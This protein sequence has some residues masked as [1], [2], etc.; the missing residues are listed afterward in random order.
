MNRADRCRC[1]RGVQALLGLIVVAGLTTQVEAQGETPAATLFLEAVRLNQEGRFDLADARFREVAARFPRSEWA[2]KASARLEPNGVLACTTLRSSGPSENRI[3]IA[4]M[5]DGF[6]R[7]QGEQQLFNELAE[8]AVRRLFS[9]SPFCEYLSFFNVHRI[10]LASAGDTV[11]ENGEVADTALKARRLPGPHGYVAVDPDRVRE[12][13]QGFQ[14]ND[15]LAVVLVHRAEQGSAA[16]GVAVTSGHAGELAHEMGHAFGGLGDEYVASTGHARVAETWC[17]LANDPDPGRVPWAH[18]LGANVPDLGVFPGGNGQQDGVWR[19]T[20]GRC[21]MAGSAAFCPVCRE[22]LVRAMYGVVSPVDRA[23]PDQA[24]RP[25]NRGQ[26]QDFFVETPALQTHAFDV[27]W[28]LARAPGP[29]QVE[30][31]PTLGRPRVVP[32]FQRHGPREWPPLTG[33]LVARTTGRRTERA[34]LYHVFRLET[35][36]LEPG[37][38]LLTLCVRDTTPWVRKDPLHLLEERRVYR[39]TVLR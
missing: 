34:T 6:R 7:T 14:W 30:V 18:W 20:P 37:G 33:R 26:Y 12:V 1:V 4:V 28:R 5:G 9:V 35:R 10:N 25:V 19:P 13:L 15:A 38:Y 32:P 3:D 31:I 39:V 21:I 27:E 8:R 16:P 24:R 36:D 17:N 23:S 2:S 22:Q 11:P 29:E